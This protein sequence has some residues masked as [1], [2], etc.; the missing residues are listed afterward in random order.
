MGRYGFELE[1]GQNAVVSTHGYFFVYRRDSD[2]RIVTQEG[3]VAEL[4]LIY[5]PLH[6]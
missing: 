1:D 3:K 4:G 2:P 6:R 5:K